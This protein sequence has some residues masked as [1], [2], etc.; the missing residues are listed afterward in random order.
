MAGPPER[1]VAPRSNR[2]RF[3]ISH[4][5]EHSM[6]QT[7]LVKIR[8]DC[9][10]GFS[11]W[12][13]RRLR[14]YGLSVWD[15]DVCRGAVT[16]KKSVALRSYC[17]K[18]HLHFAYDNGY[19]SRSTSYRTEFFAAYPPPIRHR[20]YFCA[21]CG[22]LVPAKDV[23]VDHLYPIGKVSKNLKLQ[24][25]MN[26]LGI[27]SVNDVRNLVPACSS[28][29]QKKGT[30]MGRWIMRGRFGRHPA[31]WVIRHTLRFTLAVLVYVWLIWMLMHPDEASV[32]FA[33]SMSN[34]RYALSGVWQTLRGMVA[35][36][37]K[38][39]L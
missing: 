34:I 19:G 33:S 10:N 23:T 13:I 20:F 4:F 37:G 8:I 39:G 2:H 30:R 1:I 17:R 26:R 27:R 21:Y 7:N 16:E 11:F 14:Q 28:C 31:L 6:K 5:F 22:R 25:K 38:G 36:F 29:N 3:F 12:N 24:K 32:S 35:C 18:A 15:R 9:P